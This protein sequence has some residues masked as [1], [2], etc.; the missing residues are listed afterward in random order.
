MP[1]RATSPDRISIAII[2]DHPLYRDGVVQTLKRTDLF[3][4]VAEGGSKD[5]ALR[6]AQDHLPDVMLLDVNIP[7]NGV[8]AAA[9]IGRLCPVVKIVFLT[10]SD[11]DSNVFGGLQA[12]GRGYVLKGISGPELANMLTAVHRGETIIT[13]GLA[14][15]LLTTMN[16]SGGANS[17]YAAHSELTVREDEIL[18]R[19]TEGLT[20]KEVAIA[21]GLTEKTVKHYMTNIMQKLHVRN[22]VEAAMAR[23]ASATKKP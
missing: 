6:I 8:E 15:R 16:R 23:R 1:N 19:V 5:E 12:G 7:G 4:V 18:D 21:L 14:G 20:N 13:P 11:A 2:D 22:R 3:D 10:A 17:P 9:E